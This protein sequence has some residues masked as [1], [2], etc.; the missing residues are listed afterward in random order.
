MGNVDTFFVKLSKKVENSVADITKNRAHDVF[1]S[2]RHKKSLEGTGSWAVSTDTLDHSIDKWK[3]H[4]SSTTSWNIVNGKT[5]DGVF[6]PKFIAYGLPAGGNS[7]WATSVANGTAKKLV[8]HNGRVFSTQLPQGIKPYIS[9]QQKL[10][11]ED[12]QNITRDYNK[13]NR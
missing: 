5:R 13:G 7:L 1:N 4:K 8:A 9:R 3:L 2:L 6:Y 12:M 10:F 11:R